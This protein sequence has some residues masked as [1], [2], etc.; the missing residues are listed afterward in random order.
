MQIEL[1]CR[2]YA[3]G[4]LTLGQ[5]ARWRSSTNMPLACNWQNAIFRVIIPWKTWILTSVMLVVSNTSPLSNL[6]IIDRLEILRRQ[7]GLINIPPAVQLEL[8]RLSHPA[9]QRSLPRLL[10]GMGGC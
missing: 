7:F 5:G 4:W 9:A 6:A 10:I 2:F 8:D 3:S 1:A